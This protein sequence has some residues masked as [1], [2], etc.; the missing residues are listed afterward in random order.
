MTQKI[1]RSIFAVASTVLILSFVIIMGVFYRHFSAAQ[2]ERLQA[3][4]SLAVQGVEMNGKL[5]LQEIETE[6]FRVTWIAEDGTVLLDT[7][8]PAEQMENHGDREEIREALEG[9]IGES[10]RNSETLTEKTVYIARRLSDGTVLRVSSSVATGFSVFVGVLPPLLFIFL[11][12]VLLSIFLARRMTKKIMTPLKSLNLDDPL[13]NNVYEELSP[14]LGRINKQ[15]KQIAEQQVFSEKSRREFTANVSHELKTPLQS[16][17]GSAELMENG[18]VKQEDMP[19]F[20]GHIRS[21]ASRLVTLIDD[22]IRLSQL[23]ENTEIPVE[24]VNLYEIALE[25][26]D[27][28]RVSAEKKNVTLSLKGESV[29]MNGVR[30]YLYE[31]VYNLCDNAIRYNVEGGTAD[32]H[33]SKDGSS[34][35]LEVKDTGIGIAPKHQKRVFERFYRVDKSHSKETGGTGLGLS[36][37]KHAVQYHGG[38]LEIESALEE[39]TTIR[40]TF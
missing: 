9:G 34:V 11:L 33:I 1:F 39:G 12:A 23:D 38:Q 2:R 24:A 14:I 19:R 10:S 6:D 4:V 27:V 22:I 7:Q 36:I 26:L 25:V 13:E 8:I 16:I 17:I 3:E 32:V 30:R 21:E 40:I 35:I 15:R 5:Y 29:T 37:V 20:V 31:I 28:L 18:L